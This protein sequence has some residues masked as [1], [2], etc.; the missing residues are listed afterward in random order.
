MPIYKAPLEDVAFL[1]DD[2][3]QIDRYDNLP[4]FSDASADVR[5]AILNEAARDGSKVVLVEL[6]DP[7]ALPYDAGSYYFVPMHSV[8][9]A[10]AEVALARPVVHAMFAS[11]R[12]WIR[13]GLANFAQAIIREHQAGR[14]AALA[15]LGQFSPSLAIAEEE[16]H[17]PL[18]PAAFA[19]YPCR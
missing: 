16:S 5:E 8:P 6:T 12:P 4:G 10:A 17:A 2:V 19:L 18:A 15:Y 9:H 11:P 13:E 3:F 1:L 7:D 14:A